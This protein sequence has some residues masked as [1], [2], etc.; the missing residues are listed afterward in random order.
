MES[1]MDCRFTFDQ[2]IENPPTSAIFGPQYMQARLYKHSQP[3]V[4]TI[5]FNNK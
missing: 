3:E 4:I 5:F 2:G 1:L